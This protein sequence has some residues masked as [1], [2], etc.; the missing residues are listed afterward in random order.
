MSQLGSNTLAQNCPGPDC[1][2]TMPYELPINTNKSDV[3]LIPPMPVPSS[4]ANVTIS[5]GHPAIPDFTVT[6]DK[7]T[8]LWVTGAICIII[9][10]ILIYLY[11]AKKAKGKSRNQITIEMK[12][13][14]SVA[15]GN[16]PDTTKTDV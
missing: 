16:V 1:V 15:V 12:P 11:S 3:K 2:I 7:S 4:D 14:F 6:G 10:F 5:V 13:N 8:T 9:L